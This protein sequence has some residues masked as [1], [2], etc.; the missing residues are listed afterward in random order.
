MSD[1]TSLCVFCG[2]STGHNPRYLQ[3][4]AILGRQLAE[5]RIELVFGAGG[6][7]MMGAVA[8]ACLENGGRVTGIVPEHLTTEENPV[9]G[10]D[11]LIV[12]P[13]MHTRKRMMFDRASA[14][15]VLPGGFGTMD[16]TFEILTWKQLGL[17]G[18]PIV[19][20]DI[21]G[22][23]SPFLGFAES[24]LR[25]GFI[26]PRHMDLFTVVAQADEVLPALRADLQEASLEAAPE[27]F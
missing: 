9:S 20:C 19:I 10:L 15:C 17:H 13:D 2:S 7:G 27:L 14:F 8:K 23:W 1:L 25:Q 11:E 16:E 26:R 4:A 18:K 24:M 21:D 6:L 3:Q 12:V 5:Q 22:Y